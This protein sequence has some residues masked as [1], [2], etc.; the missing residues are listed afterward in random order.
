M[1][2]LMDSLVRADGADKKAIN[3]SPTKHD[4]G[5]S[6]HVVNNLF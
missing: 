6:S 4:F 5:A 3:L 1:I 2:S